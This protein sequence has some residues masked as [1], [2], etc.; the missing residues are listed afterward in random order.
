MNAGYI[1]ILK[2]NEG[3]IRAVAGEDSGEQQKGVDSSST[4]DLDQRAGLVQR[5]AARLRN[6]VVMTGTVDIISDGE[7]TVSIA[8]GHDYLGKVT[9]TGCVLGTTI[10]AFA[11]VFPSDKFLAA[12]VAMLLF[13]IAAEMAAVRQDVQGP[14]T[15]VPAF[16]DELYKLR[17]ATTKGDRSWLQVAKVDR[18]SIK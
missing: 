15:F 17:I 7:R 4:L 11:A 16:L 2:G 12:V 3:E 14:G 1:N 5:L 10:S 18:I 13:E 6:V 9:G 8:N